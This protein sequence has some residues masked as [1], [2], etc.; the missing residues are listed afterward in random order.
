MSNENEKE[1]DLG[2]T[3]LELDNNT[4]EMTRDELVD[5]TIDWLEK[6]AEE[7]STRYPAL[8]VIKKVSHA[9]YKVPGLMSFQLGFNV[10]AIGAFKAMAGFVADVT[11]STIAREMQTGF[12][13]HL[14]LAKG[15][16]RTWSET[17]S[18]ALLEASMVRRRA[19]RMVDLVKKKAH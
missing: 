17:H 6:L 18:N 8:R 7:L 16:L 14:E 15:D 11:D 1:V 5:N 12:D 9:V 10:G 13:E 3:V 4:P 19:E 2:T